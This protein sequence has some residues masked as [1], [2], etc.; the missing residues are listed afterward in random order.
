MHL[1]CNI[2]SHLNQLNLK[3]QGKNHTIADMYKA[4]KAFRLKLTL[5]ERDLQGRKL[6]F[7][8]LHQHCEKHQMREDPLMHDFVARL[9]E[10]FKERFESFNLS[11][12]LLLFLRQPFSVLAD[13]QW[14]AEAK[15][16][17]SSLDE[18]SLQLEILEMSK[19][20]LLREQHKEAS[21][22]DFW[23]KVV[24]QAKFKNSRII[25]M[26]LLSMFP[27]TYI[28]ESS[29]SIMNIIKNIEW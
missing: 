17:V 19:S 14:T 23:T 8:Y 7:P 21:V 1:L 27:S 6:H 11:S 24:S 28:C 3:L 26:F 16:L 5:F 29:F 22:S 13:W 9:A 10:N 12:E 25:A 4:V 15:R 20:D 18:A 2:M